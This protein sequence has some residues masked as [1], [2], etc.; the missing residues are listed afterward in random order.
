MKKKVSVLGC[1]MVGSAIAAD[2]SKRYRVHVYDQSPGALMALEEKYP[3][4]PFITDLSIE[5]KLK[6]AITDCDLVIS[7][8]P[9]FMG[10]ETLKRIIEAGKNVVDI[11]FFEQDPFLL[12]EF[13]MENGVIAIVDCGIAPG[14]SNIILG[15]HASRMDVGSFTCYVGGLPAVRTL[16]WQY[17]APFSPIDVLE[18]YTRPARIVRDSVVVARPALSDPEL[19]D[20]DGVGTLEAFNTDGLRTLIKTMDV[21]DM[22][23]KTMRYPGHIDLMRI[24]RDSGFFSKEEVRI[25]DNWI[26]PLAMTAKLLFDQW[27][28]KPSDID[29]TI[30]RIIVEGKG[31]DDGTT[32]TYDLL[33]QKDTQTGF[34]SMSRTT[35]YTCTAAATLVLEEKFIR[36]GICPPEYLGKQH[37]CEILKHLEKRNVIFKKTTSE[38]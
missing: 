17:K 37:F 22:I 18:E 38:G 6:E 21:P 31:K 29:Y 12:D 15:H 27:K 4:E 24:L 14:M 23:E 35:G 9:G 19:L 11:S 34:S 28:L 10:F 20:F 30:M 26:S 3:I 2:L 13:A 7:A 33:D 5:Q 8:V 1:G 36:A 32:I 25:N 16:P